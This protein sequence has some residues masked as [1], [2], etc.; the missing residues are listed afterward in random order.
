MIRAKEDIWMSICLASSSP[1]DTS[2]LQVR[3]GPKLG[4]S[5]GVLAP[6]ARTWM[7]FMASWS[8]KPNAGWSPPCW[9]LNVLLFLQL[10]QAQDPSDN[11]RFGSLIQVE[12]AGTPGYEYQKLLS[13]QPHPTGHL[14]VP[15]VTK[16]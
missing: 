3:H 5:D 4:Q 2:P 1:S 8:K 14:L 10:C 12:L 13:N 11:P 6:G 7:D 16:A 9:S 15:L